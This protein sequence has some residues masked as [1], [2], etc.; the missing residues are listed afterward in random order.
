MTV[1]VPG[2]ADTIFYGSVLTMDAAKPREGGVAVRG[3]R[4]VA[5]GGASDLHPL[6]GP[7]TRVINL[8]GH[9][10]MPGF[11]DA[12]VHL[13]G[14]GEELEQLDLSGSATF[15]EALAAVRVR[16][17][18]LGEGEWVRGAG[19]ALHRWG[20]ATIGP[21]EQAA[22]EEAAGGRPVLLRSQDHHAAWAS[23]AALELAGVGPDT[24]VPEGVIV[25]G[26]AGE[27][28][29]LLLERATELVEAA[30]PPPDRATIGRWLERA[31][32]R[33]ASLGVTTVHHMAA[34]PASY[35]RE[36]ALA[37][38]DPAFPLRVWAC[39]PHANIEEAAA[40]GVA[41]GQ[42]GENFRVG[43]AKFF[44]DG[45]LG[46]R[47]AWMLE[48]YAVGGGT[49]LAVDGPDVLAERVPLALEAG[50]TPVVHAIGD[51]A[52]R[53]VVDAFEATA[54]LW[55]A[56]GLRPRLEHAQHMHPDDVT[57]AGR[58]GIVAS[59][60][61][62]HLTFDVE[63]IVESL[64]DR[65]ER[66]YPMRSLAREGAVL[67]FGSDAPVA[68]PDVFEGLRAAAR[69]ASPAGRRLT[70][71]EAVAPDA[72]LR[73]YTAGAAYAVGAEHRS[74]RLAPGF[75]ADLVVLSHDPTVTLEGLRAVATMKAGRFTHGE[76]AL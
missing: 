38:T 76:E 3:S 55:R 39:V 36:L 6:A 70:P 37:A 5:L 73:A 27:P 50:L 67:A 26:E 71:S 18:E 28:T 74:G 65:L 4:I 72:A 54:D 23:K 13:T 69:R 17:A 22:L 56:A 66:A 44:S 20:L 60:Q 24:S 64:G 48:P 68:S 32:R 42:G 15:E 43:G 52:T 7:H 31:A 12:H 45:A 41:T 47:T 1:R 29:G 75:D 10:L 51:A 19:F 11:H 57:R 21:A 40:L 49:G 25:R 2:H 30:L 9:A 35:Y 61:P 58:L 59:M 16:A 8:G 34:E 53:V 14:L 33:F 46:S 63:S 62:V